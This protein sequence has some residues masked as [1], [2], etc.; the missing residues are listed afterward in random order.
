MNYSIFLHVCFFYF[1][2][3]VYHLI[4]SRFVLFCIVLLLQKIT[5]ASIPSSRA[6]LWLSFDASH[7]HSS[8][9]SIELL[10]H[11]MWFDAIVSNLRNLCC[12]LA[13]TDFDWGPLFELASEN[14]CE[15]LIPQMTPLQMIESNMAPA[16]HASSQ[17]ADPVGS[18]A[19]AACP[20]FQTARCAFC[21]FWQS[22]DR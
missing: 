19:H 3:T 18:Q 15:P 12:R 4:W 22:A 8:C 13:A 20:Y 14:A 16:T 21:N 9:H 5:C 7:T 2:S 11:D 10:H 1:Y 17:I 6:C